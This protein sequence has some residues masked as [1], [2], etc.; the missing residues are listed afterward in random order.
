MDLE[1]LI[2]RWS[3][4]VPP[5]LV[6]TIGFPRCQHKR[7]KNP[8]SVKRDGTLAKACSRCLQ[9]RAA[10]CRRR[11]AALVDYASYYTSTVPLVARLDVGGRRLAYGTPGRLVGRGSGIS[12]RR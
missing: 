5:N 7:C 4:T 1:L 2:A 12:Y 11:R 10:S 6:R 8:V 9:R 3:G